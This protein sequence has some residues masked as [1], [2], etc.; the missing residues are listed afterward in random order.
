MQKNIKFTS[1][2]VGV[3]V[4]KNDI[5]MTDQEFFR[6]CIDFESYIVWL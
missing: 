2:S 6:E 3:E 1:D 4:K 5:T